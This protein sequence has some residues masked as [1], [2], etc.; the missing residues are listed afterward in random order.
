M[1]TVIKPTQSSNR[2]GIW[3][4]DLTHRHYETLQQLVLDVLASVERCATW[5][6][7]RM[8]AAVIVSQEQKR[9]LIPDEMEMMISPVN[10]MEIIVEGLD[11][12]P[13]AA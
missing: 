2:R 12:S 10:A 11:A 6:K 5:D 8:P 9:R 1:K 13:L 3:E 4:L 7:Q